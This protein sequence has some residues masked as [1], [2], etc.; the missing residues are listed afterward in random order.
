MRAQTS[1]FTSIKDISDRCVLK[2]F[3]LAVQLFKKLMQAGFP[4]TMNTMLAEFYS[5][6]I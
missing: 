2:Q 4:Q 5:S 3:V 6:Q 1:R